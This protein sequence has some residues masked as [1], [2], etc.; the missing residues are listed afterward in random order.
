MVDISLMQTALGNEKAD[1]LIKGGKYV[2]VFTDEI[3]QADVAVKGEKVAYVGDCKHCIGDKTKIIDVQGSYIVPGLIDAHF[4]PEVCKLTM[5]RLAEALVP[6]GTTTIFAGMDDLWA[7]SGMK[8]V[9]F[10]L[11]ESKKTPLRILYTPYSRV[12]VTGFEPASTVPYQF[13]AAEMEKVLEWPETFGP[14]DMIIDFILGQD[15]DMLKEMEITQAKGLLVHGHD[16]M[17][18]GPRMQAF[19]STGIRSDHVPLSAGEVYEKLRAGMWVML[20]ES[21]IAHVLPDVIKVITENKVNSRHCTFCIDDIDTRDI[22]ETGHIDHQIRT[23]IKNGL[24]PITAIQ[25]A[26]LNAA[27]CH[28]MDH[29]IGSVAPG[30]IADIVVVDDLVRFKIQKV[31]AAGKLVAENGRVIEDLPSPEYPKYFYNTF[32]TA[33]K[34]EPNDLSIKLDKGKNVHSARVHVIELSPKDLYRSGREAYLPVIEGEIQPDI[35]NDIL[36]CA[37]IER[38]KKSGRIGLGFVSGF[39]LNG[40][41]ILT[42]LAPPDGN[43]IC[44]GSNKEDMATAIN[45]IV[46]I[47]GG[48]AAV[49][50]GEVLAEVALPI[51]GIMADINPRD[52]ASAEERLTDLVHEWGSPIDR[53][54]YFL[55]FLE[56]VGLPNYSI[57]EHGVISFKDQAYFDPILDR[58]FF[59]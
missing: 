2:N 30:K 50:D 22:F 42:T 5:T 14:M 46:E 4:H 53:P 51:G 36:Y 25:I 8:G 38:H 24:N 3:Y 13:G 54:F 57:T 52:M 56:I 19:L 20:C 49:K 35:E 33:R 10:A 18:S 44:L 1:L 43:I 37:V 32:H 58:A 6:T 11:D 55:M 27:E 17:E 40:G 39:N 29:L 47:G 9:R 59:K 45:H 15:K 23:V 21:P 48:Q 31:F 26:T 28:R 41:T 12:P 7:F 34:I 16:P